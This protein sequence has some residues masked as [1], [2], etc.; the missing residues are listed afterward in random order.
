MPFAIVLTLYNGKFRAG[1]PCQ[2]EHPKT[3]AAYGIGR[4]GDVTPARVLQK[5]PQ[6]PAAGTF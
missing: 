2:D 4:S 3:G 1:V 5:L 6:V